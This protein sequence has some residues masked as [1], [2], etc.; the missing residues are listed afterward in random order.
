MIN[1]DDAV[2]QKGLYQE[3]RISQKIMLDREDEIKRLVFK[4]WQLLGN[5]F[6]SYHL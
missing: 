6:L 4:L 3:K 1:I 5:M 2:E